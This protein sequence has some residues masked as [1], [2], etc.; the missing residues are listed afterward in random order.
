MIDYICTNRLREDDARKIFKSV[1]WDVPCSKS[2]FFDENQLQICAYKDQELVGFISGFVRRLDSKGDVAYV[3]FVC[4][5]P[6]Y[7]CLGIRHELINRF[8]NEHKDKV[9]Y[10]I[11]SSY[12][13]ADAFYKKCGFIYDE[14]SRLMI[15]KI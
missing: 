12:A 2:E 14:E 15:A 7:Q 11:V 1:G 6:Q 4:V 8:K 3:S 9:L 10:F 5:L 13:G